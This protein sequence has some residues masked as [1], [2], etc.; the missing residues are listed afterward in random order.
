MKERNNQPNDDFGGG[1]D[2][3]EAMRQGGTCRGGH[4]PI[5][6]GG[7]IEQ[8]KKEREQQSLDF[9]WLPVDGGKQQPTESRHN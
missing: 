4:L 7:Q 2:V 9:R 6:W 1:W 8:R 3:G 5:I